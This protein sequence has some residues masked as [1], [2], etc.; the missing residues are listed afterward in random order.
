[1]IFKLKT[2]KIMKSKYIIAFFTFFFLNIIG[3]KNNNNFT[4]NGH[5]KNAFSGYLYIE[6]EKKLDSCLVTNNHFTYSG[7]QNK[8]IVSI[9]FSAKDVLSNGFAVYLEKSIIEIELSVSERVNNDGNKIVFFTVESIKGSKT[10][11]MS[12]D[13]YDFLKSNN[14][15][16]DYQK[17][18]YEKANNI[19]VKN[20][21]NP[22]GGSV[23]S[24]LVDY[25]NR[26][27]IALK[28]MYDI[29]DKNS[30]SEF[31]LKSI[32]QN[33]YP[34]K[35]VKLNGNVFNF[36]LPDTNNKL[37]NTTS[38]KGKWFLIE[39]WASWCA[40]CSKEMPELKRVYEEN[41]KKNFEI[42]GISIDKKKEDWFKALKEEQNHWINV[43]EDKGFTGKIISKYN[44][45]G[46]PS[47]FLINPEG[48][49]VAKDIYIE[50]LEKLLKT[51]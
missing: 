37:F 15:D 33:L 2:N 49:V 43:I 44:A 16:K 5:F 21:K 29:L 39:F 22:L 27:N 48:K 26:D 4:V 24:S 11:D 31:A 7:T 35:F 13:F 1:M 46:V 47:N 30:I 41:K 9:V 23:L 36:S 6:Y 25:E 42:V 40:P 10:S 50:E 34:E 14:Q 51:L 28:K 17:T 18:L 45:N 8:A 3:A 20:P 19:I 12:K 32:E 38:L